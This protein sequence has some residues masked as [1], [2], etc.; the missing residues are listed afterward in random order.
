MLGKA[1]QNKRSR[2]KVIPGGVFVIGSHASD[3]FGL[4]SLAVSWVEC[5]VVVG[6][7]MGDV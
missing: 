2:H 7:D 1:D 6:D 3:V 5:G 4:S